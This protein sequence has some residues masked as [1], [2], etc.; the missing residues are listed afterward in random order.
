MLPRNTRTLLLALFVAGCATDQGILEPKN[1]AQAAAHSAPGL[2]RVVTSLTVNGSA[3]PAALSVASSQTLAVVAG[4]FTTT[5][6]FITSWLSTSVTFTST[7]DG[8]L[9]TRCNDTDVWTS[10]SLPGFNLSVSF[11]AQAPSAP[12]SYLVSVQAHQED[13]FAVQAGRDCLVPW[14]D[15]PR[16]LLGDGPCR[17]SDPPPDGGGERVP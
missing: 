3:A 16:G 5:D 4:G 14:P 11:S 9:T 13:A 7:S 15:R 10:T 1:V 6:E 12:G 2:G 8:S 17:R